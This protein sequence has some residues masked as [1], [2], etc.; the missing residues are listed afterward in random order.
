FAN[1]PTS[2]GLVLLAAAA[3]ALICANSPLA[4]P[5]QQVVGA[6]IGLGPTH[7][8]VWLSLADWCSEGLLAIFFLIVGLGIRR[9]MTAG[10]LSEPRAAAAPVIAAIGSVL[11]PAAIY[12][13]LNPGRTAVGWSAPS[14]TGIAFTLGVL[15]V[16]GARASTG[17]KV[18]IA[19]YAVVGDILSI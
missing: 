5:Y 9:E 17:L 7:G 14:D 8:G 12:L 6:E 16:F 15:A 4:G 10:S 11:A 18:F 3:L 1:L 2:A 13:A 19:A